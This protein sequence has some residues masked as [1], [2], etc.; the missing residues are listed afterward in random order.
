MRAKKHME[1]YGTTID[2]L[3]KVSVKNHG[4]AKN[5]PY[6]HLPMSISLNDVLASR[7]LAD[8]INSW[9]PRRFPTGRRQL[10]WPAGEASDGLQ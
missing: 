7:M 3:A 10:S 5:N 1:K 6:A 2:Q 8:P 4:N 9:M